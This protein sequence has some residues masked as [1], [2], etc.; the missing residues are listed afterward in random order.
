MHTHRYQDH[1]HLH[2]VEAVLKRYVIDTSY[3]YIHM[4]LDLEDAL[5]LGGW[6]CLETGA[7]FQSPDLALSS[8]YIHSHSIA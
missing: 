4:Y 6:I 2:E 3:I 8:L 5:S 1:K 7:S